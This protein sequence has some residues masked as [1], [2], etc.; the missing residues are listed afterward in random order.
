M[1]EPPAPQAR[2][3]PFVAALVFAVAHTQPPLYYSNQNQ[4]FLHGLA[5]AGYGDLS[6]DWLANTTDP[7]PFFSTGIELA[8]PIGTW[9]YHAMFFALLL[10]YFGS[11]WGIASALPFFPRTVAGQ[12]MFAAGLIAVHAGIV[13][14]GSVAAIGVDYPWYFQAGVANQYLLGAGLQP[15]VFG[16]LL[17][18]ALA[19]FMRRDRAEV[20]GAGAFAGLACVFHSTYL[21]PAGLLVAGMFVGSRL[22]GRKRD[23][24][25]VGSVPLLC[26]IPII[27][28]TIVFFGPTDPDR[29]AEAQR[30]IAWVRIPHHSDVNRWLD[31]VAV[32]QLVWLTGGIVAFRRTPLFIPLVV[33]GVLSLALTLVQIASGNATLALMF[34][35][36]LSAVLV[37][38][39]TVAAAACLA[40]LAENQLPTT[41]LIA[42]SVLAMGGCVIGAVVVYMNGL[43][44]QETTAEADLVVRAAE[45]RNNG[46]VY[47]LPSGFP[48]APTSRGSASSSFVPIKQS[49]TPAIFELQRFRLGTGAAV[50]VDFKSI[51]Y[52]DDEVLEWH[53][54]VTNSARWYATPDWD[55]SGVLN[56]VIAEGLTHVVVPSNTAVE[57]NRLELHLDAVAYRV[58]RIVK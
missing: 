44:Y 27:A 46:D 29:F 4:Y 58:Y 37:P 25:I 7:T 32:G 30:V 33:A 52:R 24:I 35:W 20:A 38:V 36:R 48:K 31:W 1:T 23:A 13:R 54:R 34:P 9:T 2:W 5:Q 6:R 3:L 55:T 19:G 40:R 49:N 41:P 28:L 8:Y 22:A 16:V 15:S 18:T 39:S 45:L 56:E 14:A 26:V 12:L 43:A 10:V 17:L 21:L 51:P 53:R 50:Y 57:S 47:L 42:G 11:L